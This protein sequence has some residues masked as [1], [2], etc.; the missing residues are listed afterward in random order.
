VSI[1][2][3]IDPLPDETGAGDLTPCLRLRLLTADT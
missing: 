3:R 1:G 2:A